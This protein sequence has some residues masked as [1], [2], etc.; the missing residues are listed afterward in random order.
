MCLVSDR[1]NDGWQQGSHV[2]W[3]VSSMECRWGR[4]GRVT[5]GGIDAY[6]TPRVIATLNFVPSV[7]C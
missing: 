4:L 5:S 7:P 1:L 2:F 3:E 6:T